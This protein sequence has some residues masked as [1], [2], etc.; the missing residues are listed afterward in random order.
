VASTQRARNELN[1]ANT[2]Y[3]AGKSSIDNVKDIQK[4]VSNYVNSK[5]VNQSFTDKYVNYVDLNKKN[6]EIADN[7][8]KTA[9]ENSKDNPYK[10]DY[11]GN[12]LYYLKDKDGNIKVSTDRNSGGVPQPDAAMKRTTIKGVSAQ[13][14]YDAITSNFTD[15]DIAQMKINASAHYEGKGA[16]AILRDYTDGVDLAKKVITDGVR[17]LNV[18]LGDPK[19]TQA[20]KDEMQAQINKLNNKLTDGSFIKETQDFAKS[21]EDPRN[22]DKIHYDAYTRNYLNKQATTLS[23]QS[24]KEELLDNPYQKA[25]HDDAV[26]QQKIKVDN[27]NHQ[28]KLAD[29]R[30][31]AEKLRNQQK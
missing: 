9:P 28:E 8:K 23:N 22:I 21:L 15:D 11:L 24:Y 3:K 10:T 4:K 18:E 17:K 30:L 29:L 6:I 12:T 31:D 14:M 1:T 5:D 7:L 27:W 19:Y 20:E 2:L 26:L 25:Y 16:D 13:T